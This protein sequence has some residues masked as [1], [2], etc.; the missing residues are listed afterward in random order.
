LTQNVNNHSKV[1]F[2]KNSATAETACIKLSEITQNK[3]QICIR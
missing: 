3:T 1:N 2:N